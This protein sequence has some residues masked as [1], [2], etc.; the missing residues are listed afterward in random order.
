MDP[1]HPPAAQ[2]NFYDLV[3][4]EFSPRNWEADLRE[5]F[6]S[7]RQGKMSVGEY[8]AEFHAYLVHL[9]MMPQDE[10]IQYYCRGLHDDIA[11]KVLTARPA[12]L[13]DAEETA[14]HIDD[15]ARRVCQSGH[16]PSYNQ[17]QNGHNGQ[18]G[19]QPAYQN[20]NN[21]VPMEVDNTNI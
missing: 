19:Q 17:R 21:T 3:T 7:L 10:L 4:A 6:F 15:A 11:E 9:R 16:H 1:A 8:T 18:N 2:R 12:T 20:N 13:A 5:Y 14:Y